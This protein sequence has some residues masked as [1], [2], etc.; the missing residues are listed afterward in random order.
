MSTS[1]QD[2]LIKIL[3]AFESGGIDAAKKAAQELKTTVDANSD[4]GKALS[5]I[6][7]M[8]NNKSGDAATVFKGLSG[9]MRG[10]TGVANGLATAVKGLGGA[11]GMA[12]G[13]LAILTTAVM[14]GVTAWQSYKQKQ[15]EAAE[16]ARKAAEEQK[17]A[18]EEFA[19]SLEETAQKSATGVHD[20]VMGIADGL[21]EAAK[22]AK[23][24]DDALAAIDDAQLGLE[25]A[26]L[27]SQL[28]GEKD[29]GKKLLIEQ[30]KKRL[31]AGRERQKQEAV[32]AGIAREIGDLDQ[33][34]WAANGK[35]D[36]TTFALNTAEDAWNHD[37]ATAS[38]KTKN[39]SAVLR[40]AKE[41]RREQGLILM[42]QVSPDFE[43]SKKYDVL[44]L[45]YKAA[46]ARFD[47]AM[48]EQKE[49]ERRI[50]Q[51]R[52]ELEGQVKG[53]KQAA[54][55]LKA[56]NDPQR[57]ILEKK[58]RAE[59]LKLKTMDV[60][61]TTSEEQYA[62]DAQDADKKARE[63]K[64]K[65]AREAAIARDKAMSGEARIG[66][67]KGLVEARQIVGDESYAGYP[68]IY[69]KQNA[70]AA[71]EDAA[72]KIKDGEDDAKVVQQ[73]L[74]TLQKMG[75]VIPRLGVLV[76]ELDKMDGQIDGLARQLD[77]VEL[78]VDK[79]R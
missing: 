63:E 53:A 33:A 70:E 55:E 50:A 7:D 44:D 27:D 12:A 54:E 31:K 77:G 15:E 21:K 76:N 40:K 52:A 36:E 72:N 79:L 29:E 1:D 57:Q 38:S 74:Q 19:K 41:A 35:V 46:K 48:A 60:K 75:A 13:P 69:T 18:A 61:G 30:K 34:E 39:A 51:E 8:L 67:M 64:K 78:K 9:I 43:A 23:E 45:E 73:L 2:V 3:T 58:Q 25:L 14:A 16:A 28:V 24:L 32:I 10:G 65:K 37:M 47:E 56:A 11:L 17:K 62:L 66:R 42:H 26:E 6:M 22:R 68:G 5:G 20:E 59:L 49:I 4:S 71:I